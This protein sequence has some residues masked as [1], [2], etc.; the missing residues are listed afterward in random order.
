MGLGDVLVP[1]GSGAADCG[2]F[3]GG[4]FKAECWCLQFP[5]LCNTVSPSTFQA[6]EGIA[7][8]DLLYNLPT[9]GAAAPAVPAGYTKVNPSV[10][11]AQAQIDAATATQ[12]ANQQAANAAAIDSDTGA[13]VPESSV[14]TWVWV[15]AAG[16][17]AFALVAMGGGSPGRYGR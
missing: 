4:V 3:G 2:L 15:A 8:P 9:V 12:V 10:S 1:A 6:S 16:V 17:V 7:N 14:A 11:D 5:G 13:P